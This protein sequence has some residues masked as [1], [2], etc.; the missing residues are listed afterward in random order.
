M[1]DIRNATDYTPIK[2]DIIPQ[3]GTGT[4]VAI[5]QIMTE[6][7]IFEDMY[8]PFLT[9]TLAFMDGVGL[10]SKLP[11]S[12]EEHLN[13]ILETPGGDTIEQSFFIYKVSNRSDAGEMQLVVCHFCSHEMIKNSKT[14]ASFG[15]NGELISDMVQK[16]YD[17]NMAIDKEIDIEPTLMPRRMAFPNFPPARVM[18]EMS[19]TAQSAAHPTGSDY[20]FWE[21]LNGFHFRSIQSLIEDIEPIRDSDQREI[22]HRNPQ[23]V[24]SN[25]LNAMESI[26]KFRIIAQNNNLQ[27]MVNGG[28]ANRMQVFD[29]VTG[30][31][32]IT[33]TKLADVFESFKSLEPNMP[34]GAEALNNIMEP[35][36]N[37]RVLV[38]DASEEFA[39]GIEEFAPAAIAQRALFGST[40]IDL[41][42]PGVTSRHIG[43]V[44]D[45][46]LPSPGPKETEGEVMDRQLS[47]NAMI[48]AI[49][50][51]FTRGVYRQIIQVAKDS[52][53]EEIKTEE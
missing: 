31:V 6:M 20:R 41:Q 11:I 46:R 37:I 49:N 27:Q 43:D 1:A 42:L 5:H 17:D 28:L 10:C 2:L 51:S 50:H 47:N 15:F 32:T 33:D 19:K 38:T 23:N 48:T 4:P 8:K 16:M 36:S 21:D 44:V 29:P 25:T 52:S 14:S 9:G 22:L 30:A 39:S 35:A 3:H 40:K 7:H 45:L 24:Q 13:V 26:E 18:L 53:F 12:G 34:V